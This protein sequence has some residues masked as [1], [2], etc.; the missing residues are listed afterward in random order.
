MVDTVVLSVVGSV[1]LSVTVSYQVLSSFDVF[2]I[3]SFLPQAENDKSKVN[4]NAPAK[5]FCS[6]FIKIPLIYN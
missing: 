2:V 5:I 6:F 4:A 1:V 3:S